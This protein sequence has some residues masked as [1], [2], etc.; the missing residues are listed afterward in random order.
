KHFATIGD[1]ITYNITLKNIGNTD[2]KNILFIDTIPTGVSFIPN[3]VRVD[4]VTIPGLN[5]ETGIDFIN[6]TPNSSKDITFK[7]T[8]ESIPSNGFV[9]NIA[10]VN[11]SYILNYDEPSIA[12][13]NVSNTVLTEILKAN[14]ITTKD[15]D[16]EYVEQ[17]DTITYTISIE[18][19]G[20][21]QASS[22][23]I[24]DTIPSATSFI[25][26]SVYV[27]NI[28]R[29]SLNPLLG[30]D[31]SPLNPNESK[32]IKFDIL[33]SE[34]IPFTKLL[35]NS[36]TT[37]FKYTVDPNEDP[38][39]VYINSNTVKTN[40]N[41][42]LLDIVKSVDK[43]YAQVEDT[44]VY[45]LNVTNL[46]SVN[47]NNI[48]I[49]DIIPSG[50][51]FVSNTVSINGISIPGISPSS[52]I[53]GT[54]TPNQSKLIAFDVSITTLPNNY[55]INNL[56]SG[57]YD[58][59]VNPNS[60]PI[61]SNT[62]SNTV[63]TNVIQ[64]IIETKKSSDKNIVSVGD[65]ITYTVTIENK[66]NIEIQD[67][68]FTDTLSNNVEL[69]QGS[70]SVNGHIYSP[71][72]L[73]TGINIGNLNPNK[74]DIVIYKVKVLSILG[75]NMINNT[76]KINYEYVID[77]NEPNISKNQSTNEVSVQVIDV[78]VKINKVVNKSIADINEELIY[79]IT[80]EN[81]SSISIDNILVSDNLDQDAT[82]IPNS[83]TLNGFKIPNYNPFNGIYIN[84]IQPNDIAIITFKAMATTIPDDSIIENISSV[85]YYYYN[86]TSQN[87]GNEVSNITKTEIKNATIDILKSVNTNVA[88]KDQVLQYSLEIINKGNVPANNVILTDMLDTG[89]TFIDNSLS[90]NGVNQPGININQPIYL[91]TINPNTIINIEFNALVNDLQTFKEVDNKAIVNY[92]YIVSPSETPRQNT[93][94][95]NDVITTIVDEL[96][97][98]TFDNKDRCL[99][100]T[101]KCIC[102]NACEQRDNSKFN[103]DILGI[104]TPQDLIY[105][106]TEIAKSKSWTERDIYEF[107]ILDANCGKIDMI[108]SISVSLNII[109]QRIINTPGILPISNYENK[110]IT[111][112]KVIVESELEINID[113]MSNNRMCTHTQKK[114]LSS[115]IVVDNNYNKNIS[116][117]G[118]VEDLSIIDICNNIVTIKGSIIL[119]LSQDN[120]NDIGNSN[121]NYY[122]NEVSSCGSLSNF[123]TNKDKLWNE[124]FIETLPSLNNI[125]SIVSIKGAITT[126]DKKI[127]AT[128]SSTQNSYENLSLTGKKLA[129][130]MVLKLVISYTNTSSNTNTKVLNIPY[131][132]Y[133]ML[134]NDTFICD[135]FNIIYCIEDIFAAC[136]DNS[137]FIN[138]TIL[139]K[140]KKFIPCK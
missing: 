39:E 49:S 111:S 86:G 137:L 75:D 20:N 30:I 85:K 101:N 112:R 9:E 14:I 105:M 140:A 84:Q 121:Y 36:A 133:I 113:Y 76:A 135:N 40:V 1:E 65:E 58:Y 55:I 25:S 51:N 68:I 35:L 52:I 98:H 23:I 79:T 93:T 81:L 28:N 118:C 3:S 102:S 7:T 95:S 53:I 2:A 63:T 70:F 110:Y 124:F 119:Y 37:D 61:L 71:V 17:G 88:V 132:D 116:V 8:V 48:F 29:P 27:D 46:G 38:K 42:A 128:P 43:K 72:K 87:Q 56:A 115:F 127:I 122:V 50:V 123:L 24:Y 66:G 10:S 109:R 129:V 99:I 73:D 54:L 13:S 90:I 106:N 91:G 12:K 80:V 94:Q 45:N 41:Q 104:C 26:N 62:T 22:V 114:L 96:P 92:E 82:Y 139:M 120:C 131:S 117:K 125:C 34:T 130:S 15:V 107:L 74:K 21:T 6:I 32:V 19:I 97:I 108:N 59:F 100:N 31:V 134:P 138:T 33:A 78:N 69:I 83:I 89:L 57:N 126:I 64:S 11:Y 5:P 4:S 18:N 44:L 60:Q 136:V 47:A 103:Y 77:P 67:L 16:K